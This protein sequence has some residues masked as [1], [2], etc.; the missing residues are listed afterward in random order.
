MLSLYCVNTGGIQTYGDIHAPICLD[1]LICLDAP[2]LWMPSD[3]L[4]AS[5]HTGG[6]ETHGGIQTYGSIQTQGHTNIQ[7][8]M[9]ASICLD[10]PCTYITQRKYALSD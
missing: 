10:A 3:I 6:I 2:F 4:G 1:A 8:G 9:Y 7:R 5:K